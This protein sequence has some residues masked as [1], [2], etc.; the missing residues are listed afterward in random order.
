MEGEKSVVVL[1]NW[2]QSL[3]LIMAVQNRDRCPVGANETD[4]ELYNRFDRCVNPKYM[5]R[6]ISPAMV[7]WKS[8]P[9]KTGN[10]GTTESAEE[11]GVVANESRTSAG[12]SNQTLPSSLGTGT[13]G[14]SS[15]SSAKRGASASEDPSPAET[16]F[17]ALGLALPGHPFSADMYESLRRV[18]PM[19]PQ[20]TIAV[21][22]G[23]EF[24]SLCSQFGIKSFPKL[25]FFKK[26]IFEGHYDRVGFTPDALARQLMKWSTALKPHAAPIG[27]GFKSSDR[28]DTITV[29]VVR[30]HIEKYLLATSSIT[31]S[32]ASTSSANSPTGSGTLLGPTLEPI[33]GSTAFLQPY[34]LVLFASCALYSLARFICFLRT[35]GTR[36]GL[37]LTLLFVALFML[38]LFHTARILFPL[39]HPALLSMLAYDE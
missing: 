25:L 38:A 23:Y 14:T 9:P 22:N 33:A 8:V 1:H 35:A 20:L 5:P 17:L 10:N 3:R 18:G 37:A 2:K 30:Q 19:F 13:N 4:I 7:T 28:V 15:V 24:S 31:W 29:D 21:G 11:D 26:G 36:K 6:I 27:Q 39:M 16:Q 12:F 32:N 34:E